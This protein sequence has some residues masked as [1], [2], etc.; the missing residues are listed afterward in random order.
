MATIA[1]V[2]FSGGG[3]THLMAEAIAAGVRTAGHTADLLRITGEQINQGRWQDD[4]VMARLNEADAI[5]FGS[6]TYMG[7]VAA[8]FK[9]F[10]D[11]ASSAWFAQQ[12]KD[13]IAA[14]FTHSSSP[15][16]D[17]QGTLLYLAI[18]AAQH[19]MVWIGATDMPS[20]YQGKTDGINRL[21][22]F[23]GIM[24]Q[25][26]MSMDGSPATIESGDRLTAELFGQRIAAAVARW[27]PQKVA[28]P[29]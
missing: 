25:S 17:K 10:I 16:G 13:K 15:S 2:Y 26:A 23:L 7:G 3:H 14:G 18:N 12:W 9:A 21:G 28:V 5:V 6:P 29:A 19:G 27:M 24:G 20:Q 8:Q 4:A 22:S 1:I 11:A